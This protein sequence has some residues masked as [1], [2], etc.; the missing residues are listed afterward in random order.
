MTYENG[1]VLFIVMWVIVEVSMIVM[2]I[3]PWMTPR[4][5]LSTRIHATAIHVMVF[6]ILTFSLY[7]VYREFFNNTEK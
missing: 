2:T 5:W 3:V 7:L 4:L 6:S 1:K